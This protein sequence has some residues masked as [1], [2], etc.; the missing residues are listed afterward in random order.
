MKNKFVLCFPIW[1]Y[2]LHYKTLKHL[3]RCVNFSKNNT[4]RHMFF[5]FCNRVDG[6]K[7]QTYITFKQNKIIYRINKMYILKNSNRILLI[8]SINNIFTKYV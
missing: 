6:P 4:P 2:P 7:L 1:D 5:T 3:E 8:Y